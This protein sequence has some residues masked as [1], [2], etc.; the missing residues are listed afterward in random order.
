MRAVREDEPSARSETERLSEL[1]GLIYEA[2][3]DP[4]LWVRAVEEARRFVGEPSVDVLLQF[5]NEVERDAISASTIGAGIHDI[6]GPEEPDDRRR[7]ALIVPHLQRAMAHARLLDQGR[8]AQGILTAVLD[9]V[10]TGVF[11]LG[12]NARLVFVNAPGRAMIEEGTLLVERTGLLSAVSPKVH[13]ALRDALAAAA[14]GNGAGPIPLVASPQLRYAAH[15]LPLTSGDRQATDDALHSA[16]KAVFVRKL[17]PAD[18]LPLE[19]LAKLYRFTASEVRVVDAVM[20]VDGVKALAELLGLR[21]ATVKTHL[22]NV[23]RKTGTG[24]QGQLVKLIAG[25]VE[26]QQ[27]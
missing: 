22:H 4:A 13:R 2:A 10:A 19:A 11:L 14:D 9:N 7:L 27:E 5:I 15:V 21:P 24:G 3:R 17:S 16:T 23:F 8:A 26:P 25:F 18:P 20:K 12:V 6:D 1:I